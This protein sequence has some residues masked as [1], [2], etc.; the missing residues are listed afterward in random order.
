MTLCPYCGAEMPAPGPDHPRFVRCRKCGK[1]ARM[2]YY[3]HVD[4]TF[5]YEYHR[6]GA[7]PG[8]RGEGKTARAQVR[9][10]KKRVP[11]GW[12]IQ[13]IVDDWLLQNGKLVV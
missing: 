13:R 11:D 1:S 3:D 12:T 2:I 6:H 8:T 9:Y 10:N 4:G 7:A 5:G